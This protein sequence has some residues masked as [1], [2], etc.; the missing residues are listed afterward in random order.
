MDHVS[1]CSLIFIGTSAVLR[2][3]RERERERG[4]GMTDFSLSLSLIRNS[5][6]GR[7]A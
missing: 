3:E 2:L 4:R 6:L 1:H 7:P 5:G